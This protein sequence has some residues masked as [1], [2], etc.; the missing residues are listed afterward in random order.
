M[1]AGETVMKIVFWGV[2]GSYPV[3]GK[4]TLRYGG[5]TACLGIDIGGRKVIFDAGTGI[6]KLGKE[7]SANFPSTNVALFL[8]HNHLDHTAGLL[9][10]TPTYKKST[11]MHIFGPQDIV[12]TAQSVLD[13]LSLPPAHPVPF[14]DMGMTYSC[15]TIS[16][17]NLVIW[18]PESASP[19]IVA[20]DSRI[21]GETIVVRI[22]RNK[23]HPVDG[24]LNFRLEYKDK[25][26]VYASD[27]EGD[28]D[29]GD[30]ELVAFARNADLLVHDCQYTFE[31]YTAKHRGWGHSTPEMAIKTAVMAGVKKVAMFHYDPDYDDDKLD[32]MAE[33][34]KPL[35]PGAF[36]A[37]EG[38]AITL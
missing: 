7:L 32:G 27:V 1:G 4:T 11:T 13:E 37:R 35:F 36:F 20:S 19:E 9:Y 26:L 38:D 2:R 16:E 17:K 8:S 21:D 34:T 15:K 33:K 23:R 10:F 31:E 30:P 14:D 25:A 12:G 18:R 22:L 3:P 24:V 29:N 6:I 28:I 5:N